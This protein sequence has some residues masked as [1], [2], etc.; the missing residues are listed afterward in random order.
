M[1]LLIAVSLSWALLGIAY[2]RSFPVFFPAANLV[3]LTPFL[4]RL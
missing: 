4:D 3:V 1:L 2:E